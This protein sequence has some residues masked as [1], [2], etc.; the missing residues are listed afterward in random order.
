VISPSFTEEAALL[1]TKTL[2]SYQ[3]T[4]AS[5]WHESTNAHALIIRSKDIIS[6][7]F[8][9]RFPNLELVVTATSGFDHIDLSIA[10]STNIKF[11]HCPEAN[12]ASASEITFWHILNALKN[13]KHLNSQSWGW[14]SEESLGTELESKKVSLIGLGRIGQSVA[15]KLQAFGCLVS[16][17]DP[18][19]EQGTFDKLSVEN[20]SLEKALCTADILSLHCPLTTKTHKLIN[21]ENLKLMKN[22][23]VLVNC[24]RG[25]L[26]DEAALIEAL[27]NNTISNVCLDVFE[28]EPLDTSSKLKKMSSVSLSPHV[29]GYTREAQNKSALEA[30]QQVKNWFEQDQPVLNV[31][32]PAYKWAKDLED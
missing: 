19:V 8:L 21:K 24:A 31:L 5:D 20:L 29:G 15:R 25:P 10:Q 18:Y 17:H 32:P 16:A 7:N 11:C 26:I 6:K 3:S 2:N 13:G 23:A 4:H 12:V 14:R 22:S 1:I 27:E 28:A 9:E 30:A